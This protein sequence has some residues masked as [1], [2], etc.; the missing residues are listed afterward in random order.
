MIKKCGL[1]LGLL[2]LPVSAFADTAQYFM[3]SDVG[4]SARMIRMANIEGFSNQSSS[5]FDNPS[6]IGR[7]HV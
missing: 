7:A 1:I 4:S 3:I 6:E 2:F 5:V